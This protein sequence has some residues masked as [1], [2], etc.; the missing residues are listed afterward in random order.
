[1]SKILLPGPMLGIDLGGTKIF[2]VVTDLRGKVLGASKKESRP[3]RGADAVI[4][5]MAD[6]ADEALKKSGLKMKRIAAAGLGVPSPV[7]VSTGVAFFSPNLGWRDVPVGRK[8]SK[9]IGKPVFVDNDVNLGTLGEFTMGAGR[10]VKNMVG[11]FVGTGIGGGIIVNGRL[12]RGRNHT[13]GEVGHM[14]VVPDGPL[15]GCGNRGCLEAVASRSA[16]A[17]DIMAGIQRG[18]PTCITDLMRQSDNKLRSGV[19]S[20]AYR[21]G[22]LL[23]TE[24]LNRA[25]RYIGIAAASLLNA[26]GTDRMVI[27]GGVFEALG[28][29]LIPIVRQSFHEHA[30]DNAA[31]G[32]DVVCAKLGD[33]AV[34]L[35]G[36]VHAVMEMK[37]IKVKKPAKK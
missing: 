9:L 10:G 34:A 37:S 19:L 4:A 20:Q 36:V 25:A 13:G 24:V 33:S 32:V 22:D 7:D 16:I 23:T 21:S 18:A 15:C 8:L 12:L 28:D 35:G 14:I 2:A 26:L 17:R 29:L 6:A 11:I 1:M 27:G 5:R 31:D 30:F 3:E